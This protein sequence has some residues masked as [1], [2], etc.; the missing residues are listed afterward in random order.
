MPTIEVWVVLGE[1]GSYEAAADEDTAFDRLMEESDEDLAGKTCR[2]VKLN[3]TMSDPQDDNES[4]RA[5]DVAVPD[6]AGQTVE[7]ETE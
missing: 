5:V 1:D 2:V 7:V 4:G 3:V 6:D